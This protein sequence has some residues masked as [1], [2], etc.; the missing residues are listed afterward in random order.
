MWM[1]KWNNG[2]VQFRPSRSSGSLGH[3]SRGSFRLATL[4]EIV[5]NVN[6][7]TLKFQPALRRKPGSRT[8][9]NGLDKYITF[10]ANGGKL[11]QRSLPFFTIQATTRFSTSSNPLGTTPFTY[12]AP[13]AK[14]FALGFANSLPSRPPP[15]LHLTRFSTVGEA[16]ESR[17]VPA[18]ARARP[19]QQSTLRT[20]C[21]ILHV[22]RLPL[23]P[24]H[25]SA[26]PA[27]ATAPLRP[28]ASRPASWS[29]LEPSSAWDGLSA[30]PPRTRCS[31]AQTRL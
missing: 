30:G 15:P 23:R 31:C 20:K 16:C 14:P 12:A 5:V 22:P 18:C 6:R 4:P 21:C 8:P 13:A 26:P 10:T 2:N 3:H 28:P 17:L 29:P 24:R 9:R 27:L 25:A 1:E 7:A 19:R 11:L